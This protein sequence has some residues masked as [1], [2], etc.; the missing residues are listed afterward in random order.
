MENVC[1]SGGADGADRLFHDCASAAGHSIVNYSFPAHSK[2]IPEPYG[3]VNLT[4]EELNKADPFLDEANQILKRRFPT[5]SLFVDNLLRR[6]Y[7]QIRDTKRIYAVGYLE[8]GMP[9]GGT[10]WAVIMG[11]IYG[12]TP[13]YFFDQ[14][15]SEWFL[16]WKGP[17]TPA[18]WYRHVPYKPEGK[19]TGI[20]SRSLTIRGREA[21]RDL[22]K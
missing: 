18:T 3:Y 12:V 5:G 13:I 21:I 15:D 22:Y 9:Q 20:G 17:T 4:Q 19:Y 1:F 8:D 14:N 6:N 7:W 11:I 16:Y 10:A 2:K